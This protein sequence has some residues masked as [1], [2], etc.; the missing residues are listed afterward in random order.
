MADE[1][2]G[3]DWQPTRTP[4]FARRLSPHTGAM[5]A[6]RIVADLSF[7]ISSLVLAGLAATSTQAAA[8]II[9]RNDL[10]D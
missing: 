8:Q 1:C 2:P 7:L 4:N 5:L 10:L 9:S 6:L 3:S